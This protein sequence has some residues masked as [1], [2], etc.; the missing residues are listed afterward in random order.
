MLQRRHS[1]EL[2]QDVPEAYRTE[3]LKSRPSGMPHN[4]SEAI[5]RHAYSA[6][7]TGARY[8]SVLMLPLCQSRARGT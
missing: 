4:L 6:F 2:A 5:E 3:L 8:L 1:A 7:L